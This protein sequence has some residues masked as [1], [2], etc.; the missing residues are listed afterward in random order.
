MIYIYPRDKATSARLNSFGFLWI[1]TP[2]RSVRRGRAWHPVELHGDPCVLHG[3][4]GSF[5]TGD[6]DVLA[7]ASDELLTGWEN[8]PW[9]PNLPENSGMEHLQGFSG[10]RPNGKLTDLS[11]PTCFNGV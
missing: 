2:S 9:K 5:P 7:D 11:I 10:K 1:C 6:E 4:L 3:F 8:G